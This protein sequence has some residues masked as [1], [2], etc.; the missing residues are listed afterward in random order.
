MK[1]GPQAV[2][3]GAEF[4]LR[5]IEN[6]NVNVKLRS[7]DS[8]ALEYGFYIYNVQNNGTVYEKIVPKTEISDYYKITTRA[9]HK[10]IDSTIL[11]GKDEEHWTICTGVR[12]NEDVK[13]A[14]EAGFE[15]W[16]RGLY[17]KKDVPIEELEFYEVKS[18]YDLWAN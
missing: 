14:V 5:E 16:E 4:R 3:K 6:D 18:E 10:G 2:Y 12:N 11:G 7:M 13:R 15:M 8:S 1:N 9:I 17:W